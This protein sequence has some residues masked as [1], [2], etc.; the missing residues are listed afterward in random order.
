MRWVEG[1]FEDDQRGGMC[2]AQCT[3]VCVC[4][5]VCHQAKSSVH[6]YICVLTPDGCVFVSCEGHR[7]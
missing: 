4:L 2:G 5:F 7:L 3:C 6:A 1:V